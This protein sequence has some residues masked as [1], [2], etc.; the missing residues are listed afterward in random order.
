MQIVIGFG[1]AFFFFLGGFTAFLLYGRKV[2]TLAR[3]IDSRFSPKGSILEVDEIEI[4]GWVENLKH[5]N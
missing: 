1:L 4:E 2:Q 3:Q 5:E